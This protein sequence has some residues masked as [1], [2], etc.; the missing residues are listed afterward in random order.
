MC[1]VLIMKDACRQDVA[2]NDGRR[3][4][5]PLGISVQRTGYSEK[6]IDPTPHLI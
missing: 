4:G 6:V 1:G 5:V 2:L 3:G